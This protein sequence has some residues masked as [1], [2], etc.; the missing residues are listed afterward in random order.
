MKK[1]RLLSAFLAASLLCTMAPPATVLATETNTETVD[2]QASARSRE[3][4]I[5]G[6]Q[7]GVDYKIEDNAITILSSTVLTLSGYTDCSIVVETGTTANLFLNGFSAYYGDVPDL[8][9]EENSSVCLTLSSGTRQNGLPII[10]NNG[11]ITIDGEGDLLCDVVGLSKGSGNLTIN[12][13]GVHANEMQVQNLTINGG[14]ITYADGE[15]RLQISVGSCMINGGLIEL[16]PAQSVTWAEDG[17]PYGW[18]PFDPPAISADNLTINGGT[19][20]AGDISANTVYG[21]ALPSGKS[22][23]VEDPSNKS[24]LL[25]NGMAVA[26]TVFYTVVDEAQLG[27]YDVDGD[28]Y[29][30]NLSLIHI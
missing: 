16:Q 17:R 30:Y 14:H 18:P 4:V 11:E 13:G 7:E 6:G 8:K 26:G 12:S 24:W 29:E 23:M 21:C 15:S 20:Y 10:E 22:L 5:K 2:E 19:F 28:G 27:K 25:D 1:R 3:L 9:V